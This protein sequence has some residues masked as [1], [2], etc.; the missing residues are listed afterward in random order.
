MKAESAAEPAAG[1]QGAGAA[2][3]E[4]AGKQQT[5]KG[6]A[7]DD[8]FAKTHV[9]RTATLSVEVKSVTKA[10]AKA[11][12]V[13][14]DAGGVVE[15]ETTE[16][17]D[18]THVASNVVLRVPEAEYDSVLTE[19]AGAGKLLA[20]SA[21][22]K[23][24]T[25]QVV[26]VNSRIATQRA[27]VDRVRKLMDQAEDI[28]DVVALESQLNT[29]QSELEA[30]LAKQASLADRTTMATVTLDLSERPKE[31][32]DSGD[33]DPGFLDAL[34][35]GWDALVTVL[36]WIV[37]VIAASLPFVAALAVLLGLW[38]LFGARLRSR[39]TRTP[40]PAP[41]PAGSH[42]PAAVPDPAPA[43]TPAPDADPSPDAGK[44]D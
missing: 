10:L 37:V 13:A 21:N 40:A 23:D 41:V 17:I 8:K 24:V 1:R 18:D 16:R 30:L 7:V 11:R 44:R 2:A 6:D 34:G 33:G 14:L 12:N 36:R 4:D 35:G 26:D 5:G 9:I 27:S 32:K 28:T 29:R 15:D 43:P 22:A 3:D 25:E 31:E 20:R 42:A 38:L 19:L 39:R